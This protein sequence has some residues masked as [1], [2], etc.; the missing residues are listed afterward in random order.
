MSMYRL[1]AQGSAAGA[2][3]SARAMIQVRA[4]VALFSSLPA[5]DVRRAHLDCVENL[6]DYLA[7][8]M[9]K[10][11]ANTPVAVL[12]DGPLTIPYV[13]QSIHSLKIT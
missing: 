2:T 6:N 12:P 1:N 8:V 10:L 7:S 11:G 3:D 5:D 9:Q 4:R 13:Q